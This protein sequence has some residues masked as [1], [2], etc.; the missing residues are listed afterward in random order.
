LLTGFSLPLCGNFLFRSDLLLC[1]GLQLCGNLLRP[2]DS[3]VLL[4]WFLACSI[5]LV[6]IR[7]LSSTLLI[8]CHA[9]GFEA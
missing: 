5:L 8:G 2:F 7:H 6:A 9:F 1:G 4:P 3:S